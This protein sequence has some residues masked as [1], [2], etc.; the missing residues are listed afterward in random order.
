MFSVSHNKR[1]NVF[2]IIICEN[3]GNASRPDY[4]HN[5]SFPISAIFP[6]LLGQI[7]AIKAKEQGE[8]TYI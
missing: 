6:K 1:Y 3:L 7:L 2:H 5:L 8:N 4:N